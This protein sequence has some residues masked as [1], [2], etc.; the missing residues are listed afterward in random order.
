M[1]TCTL[2]KSS[3]NSK[4]LKDLAI[5]GCCR[6]SFVLCRLFLFDYQEALQVAHIGCGF[7]LLEISKA[8]LEVV[9]GTI[10]WGAPGGPR[11]ASS[12]SQ[13]GIVKANLNGNRALNSFKAFGML[14]PV[15][16]KIAEHRLHLDHHVG[17]FNA[18]RKASVQ[19]E[20]RPLL[21]QRPLHENDC[22][23]L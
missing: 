15:F 22:A 23:I 18:S 14:L 9:M 2:Q 19:Q 16:Q 12:F 11:D 20:Q 7:S 10:P 3:R 17:M 4:E 13:S 5:P 8:H 1:H 6:E 21:M